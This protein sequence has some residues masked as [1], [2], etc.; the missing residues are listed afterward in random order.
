M[1]YREIHL[2][3]SESGHEHDVDCWCEPQ[4]YWRTVNT[5][6]EVFIVEHEDNHATETAEGMI[7]TRAAILVIRSQE[8]DWITRLLDR[9]HIRLLPPHED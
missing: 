4:G 2:C 8:V 5:G 3:P 7:N 1:D 6:E 9:V